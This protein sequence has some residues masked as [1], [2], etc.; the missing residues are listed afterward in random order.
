MCVCVCE[1]VCARACVCVWCWWCLCVRV[2]VGGG[3]G[4][5][6][7]VV[8][9]CRCQTG[10]T[11][12]VWSERLPTVKTLTEIIYPLKMQNLVANTKVCPGTHDQ[13]LKVPWIRQWHFSRL[14]PTQ[15][16]VSTSVC[17]RP[18]SHQFQALHSVSFFDFTTLSNGTEERENR[19]SSRSWGAGW[20]TNLW[21]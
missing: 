6:V 7:C 5:C 9:V 14:L 11:S 2:C 19:P 4:V 12:L 17:G 8:Y 16:T 13:R 18:A 1:C 3:G 21:T 10:E 15:R 20:L